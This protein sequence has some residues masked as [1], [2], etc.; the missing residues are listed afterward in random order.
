MNNFIINLRPA[1]VLCV[2]FT[3]LFGFAYPLAITR[4]SGVIFPQQSEGS[5]IKNQKGDIIGS[6]LVGQNFTSDKYFWG[7]L[8]ATAPAYNAA[9]SS[10]S[11]LGVNNPALLEN[12]K[13][14]IEALKTQGQYIPVD[15]VTA[16]GS[17]LDPDISIKAAIIQIERIAKARKIPQNRLEELIE[18][19]TQNPDLFILGE[20]RV[21]VLTLNIALDNLK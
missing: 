17:G 21:N 7:R 19:N 3:M 18:Q 15:L 5:L 13:A 20:K 4:V 1:I 2:L 12:V 9:I 16:S 11:N 14:R 6:A 10:G 8:S